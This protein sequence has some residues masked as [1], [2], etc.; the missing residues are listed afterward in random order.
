MAKTAAERKREQ[1]ER[2]KKITNINR[3]DVT[4]HVHTFKLLSAYADFHQMTLGEAVDKA[5]AVLREAISRAEMEAIWQNAEIRQQLR[6][7]KEAGDTRTI[8]LFADIEAN[9]PT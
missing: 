4:C 2:A 9:A 3:L 8:P 6:Q 1:R 7:H 5:A